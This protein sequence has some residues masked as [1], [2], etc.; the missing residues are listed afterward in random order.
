MGDVDAPSRIYKIEIAHVLIWAH[1]SL[2]AAFAVRA[3][4]PTT[5]CLAYSLRR[6]ILPERSLDSCAPQGQED[7]EVLQA[8]NSLLQS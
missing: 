5:E 2:A 4:V 6:G 7:L 8:T 1:L 3:T